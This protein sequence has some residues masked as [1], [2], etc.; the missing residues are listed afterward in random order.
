MTRAVDGL[1]PDV[2]YRQWV[3]V[4]PKR[5]RYFL[6]QRPELV[7]ELC[8]IFA[9]AIE[10]HLKRIAQAGDPSQIHFVQ[11]FG[12]TLN[13]HLHVHAVVSD[14]LFRGAPKPFGGSTLAFH[15]TD[16]PSTQEVSRVAE[17]VRRKVLNRFKRLKVLPAE[18]IAEMLAWEHSGFSVHAGTAVGAGDADALER[19]LRYCARPA[20]A[21]KRM[22]YDKERNFARYEAQSKRDGKST[23]LKFEPVE[24]LRRLALLAPPPRRNQVRY[25]GA[26]GP[27]SAIRG[28]V[29]E[30][31]ARARLRRESSRSQSPLTR[32][33]GAAARSWAAAL[34]RI[35]EIELLCPNCRGPLVPVAVILDDGELVRLLTYLGL[36]VDLPKTAPARSPPPMGQDEYAQ[37]DSQADASDGIDAPSPED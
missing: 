26:L 17:A 4:V 20:I 35:F 32:A 21:M 22:S 31:A 9:R 6:H 18:V 11:R 5:I 8:A 14:G 2:G 34:S 36:P 7:G 25:Y 15:R 1:L 10:L 12:S 24:F 23:A 37:L 16:S 27:N 3:L 30:E 29:T 13:L 19:L 28:L 33:V